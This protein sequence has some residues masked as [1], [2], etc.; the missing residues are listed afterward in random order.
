MNLQT[1]KPGLK[2]I[3]TKMNKTLAGNE[4]FGKGIT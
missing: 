3:A 1:V 4:N 2:I